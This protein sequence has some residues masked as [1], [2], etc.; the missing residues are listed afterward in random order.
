MGFGWGERK[1]E[2]RV[3]LPSIAPL[4]RVKEG[5]VVVVRRGCALIES[6][7]LKSVIASVSAIVSF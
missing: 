3:K 7:K 5:F 6:Q 4:L 1:S 2:K